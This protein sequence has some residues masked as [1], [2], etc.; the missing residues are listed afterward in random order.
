MTMRNEP[1]RH[2][3]YGPIQLAL[4]GAAAI[5][6]VVFAWIYAY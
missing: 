3:D 2:S 6:L 5:V 4:Y 1:D